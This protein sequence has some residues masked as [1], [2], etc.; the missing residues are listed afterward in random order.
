VDLSFAGRLNEANPSLDAIQRL[1]AGEPISLGR[2]GDRW[3]IHDSAGTSVGRL[4]RSYE[5]PPGTEFVRAEVSAV[6]VRRLDDSEIGYRDRLQRDRWHVVVPEL[7]FRAT[8]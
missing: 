4:A 2:K 1:Q 8:R 7:V 5:P 6:M 3:H